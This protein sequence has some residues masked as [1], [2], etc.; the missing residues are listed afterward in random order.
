M[1]TSACMLLMTLSPAAANDIPSSYRIEGVP[2]YQQIDSHGC[3]AAAMQMIFDYHG[4][5]IDQME[6]YNAARI[7]CQVDDTIPDLKPSMDIFVRAA[8][9]SDLSFTPGDRFPSHQV[10]GYTDRPLGYSG[11]FYASDTP[12][13]DELKSILAQGYPVAILGQY[14]VDWPGAHYRVAV[15]YD[16]SEGV[17]VF[18]DGWC[19]DLKDDM[20][21]EGSTAQSAGDAAVDPDFAGFRMTYEDFLTTW[22]IETDYNDLRY[23]AVFSAPW[24]V[25]TTVPDSVSVGETFEVSALVTYTCVEPFG[26]DSCPVFAAEDCSAWIDVEGTV[27]VVAGPVTHHLGGMQAG[28]TVEI[29]WTLRALTE[30]ESSLVVSAGGYV[31]GHIGEWLEYPAFDYTDMIGGTSSAAIHIL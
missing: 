14:L 18:N 27:E 9:F 5:F 22:N 19:R 29:T 15:G 11:F 6:I 25:V 7:T 28:D 10:W 2:L 17:I 24:E 16:D 4:P 3:G 31:S 13:L 8:H 30:G 12:W 20:E 26:S 21:Y 1:M 23:A